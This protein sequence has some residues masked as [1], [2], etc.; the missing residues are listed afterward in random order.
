MARQKRTLKKAREAAKLSQL[1]L[2]RRSKIN[3]A[4]ISRIE[5]GKTPR[6]SMATAQALATALGVS[7]DTL[8][9]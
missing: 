4:T 8:R 7:V 5:A 2:A 9:F 6:P 3:Q 1:A